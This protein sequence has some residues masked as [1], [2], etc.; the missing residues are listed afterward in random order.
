M[1]NHSIS[2]YCTDLLRKRN[3]NIFIIY[4]RTYSLCRGM[5]AEEGGRGGEGR[6]VDED[7]DEE[8]SEDHERDREG[9]ESHRLVTLYPPPDPRRHCRVSVWGW[10]W[11]SVVR[12][13]GWRSELV[14]SGDGRSHLSGASTPSALCWTWDLPRYYWIRHDCHA[15]ASFQC[16][17]TCILRWLRPWREEDD[18]VSHFL[19]FS[20]RKFLFH[21]RDFKLYPLRTT[22]FHI[23]VCVSRNWPLDPRLVHLSWVKLGQI[24][25]ARGSEWEN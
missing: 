14:S 25:Q 5:M 10:S 20:P 19:T 11:C 4:S 6:E 3:C 12:K 21:P 16:H 9:K 2:K 17:F 13:E 8:G 15:W 22:N 18:R 1:S 24:P 7:G 23:I